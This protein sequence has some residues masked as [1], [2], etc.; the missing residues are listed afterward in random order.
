MKFIKGKIYPTRKYISSKL[1]GQLRQCF[2]TKKN[3]VL[4]GCFTLDM[5]P[6][7]PD[8]LL[9][10]T[11]NTTKKTA[12][13][14]ISQDYP[15]R[16]FIYRRGKGWEYV[17]YYQ[18]DY[19][20]DYQKIIDKYRDGQTRKL[21]MV[22]FT[23]QKSTKKSKM[24]SKRK[25]KKSIKAAGFGDSE[26]NRQVEQKAIEYVTK[27]Y[28]KDGW[29]VKSVEKENLGYDLYC[30]KGVMIKNI[31]V[32]GISGN[33]LSFPITTNE[34][35]KATSNKDFS[36]SIVLSTLNKPKLVEYTGEEFIKLF[37]LEPISYKAELKKK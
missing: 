5:N 27:Y 3:V 12:K 26:T 22:I 9:M 17:G 10:G 15:I 24:G 30:K 21:S 8:I 2:P 11:S 18:A 36:L 33:K 20:S 34:V 16:F 4:Y 32:K 19:W 23:K 1:G 35:N 37:N 29:K 7:A 14:F 13:T 28:Q 6:G 31:E 25:R